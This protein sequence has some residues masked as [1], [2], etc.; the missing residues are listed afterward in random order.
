MLMH[1]AFSATSVFHFLI[2]VYSVCSVDTSE[3]YLFNF[4]NAA[5]TVINNLTACS[6]KTE[7]DMQQMSQ[8]LP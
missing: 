4:L 6:I 5:F 7:R 2:S 1:L 8:R 3:N